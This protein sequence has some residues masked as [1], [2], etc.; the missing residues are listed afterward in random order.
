M[1]M[2]ALV[3]GWRPIPDTTGLLTKRLNRLH[4]RSPVE[5]RFPK[6]NMLWYQRAPSQLRGAKTTTRRDTWWYRANSHSCYTVCQR[7]MLPRFGVILQWRTGGRGGA[8]RTRRGGGGLFPSTLL[9]NA[10][11]V[12]QYSITLASFYQE[13]GLFVLIQLF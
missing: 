9:D 5:V 12:S 13:A 4:S 7:A 10:L 11:K 6:T 3:S 2:E 1:Q 8:W